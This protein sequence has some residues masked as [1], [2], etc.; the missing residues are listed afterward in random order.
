MARKRPDSWR[1]AAITAIVAIGVLAGSCPSAHAN[2]ELVGRFG[3]AGVSA[4]GGEGVAGIA[5][6]NATGDVYVPDARGHR[7]ER[8]SRDGVFL[9][10]WG[11]G[12]A[13]GAPEFQ[14]CTTTCQPEGIEGDGA[15]QFLLPQGAAVDQNTGDVYILD[16]NRIAGVIQEFTS[17]GT[18]IGAF[19][20]IGPGEAQ[21]GE[22]ARERNGIAVGAGGEVYIS[23]QS[24]AHGPRLMKFDGAGKYQTGQD[25]GVGQLAFPTAISVA[26]DGIVAIDRECVVD[27]FDMS[28]TLQWQSPESCTKESLTTDPTTDNSFI[29]THIGNQYDV[30]DSAGT[31]VGQFA[32]APEEEFTFG[33]A[34]DPS[35]TWST[36]RP[37]GVLYAI[38]FSEL[39]EHGEGLIFAQAPITP[40]SIESTSVRYVG[41]HSA[42]MTATINA[43]GSKTHYYFEVGT[44]GPCSVAKCT[45]TPA[46]EGDA[47][48][49]Q[50]GVTASVGL[51]TLAPATTY[52]YRVV[53]TNAGGQTVGAD[54]AFSTFATATTGLPDERAYELVSPR[55]KHGGQVFPPEPNGGSCITGECKPGINEAPAPMQSTPEGDVIAYE[56]SPFSPNLGPSGENEY[57]SSRTSDGWRTTDLSPFTELSGGGQGFKALSADL[58]RG[59]LFDLEPTLA[60][61]APEGYANLYSDDTERNSFTPII[62][63]RPPNRPGG[64]SATSF[65]P[66][67]AGASGDFSDVVFEANDALT[68]GAIDG[69][70]SSDNLYVWDGN[71]L[72]LANILPSGSPDGPDVA[73]GSG[74]ELTS[75]TGGQDYS[76]AISQDGSR[77]FWTDLATGQ[78]YLRE[79]TSRTVAVPDAGRFLTAGVDGRQVLLSDG[80]L[81]DLETHQLTDLTNGAG[82]FAGILGANSDLTKVFFV[83]SEA[84]GGAGVAGGNNLYL[85]RPGDLTYIAT[86]SGEDRA[87]WFLSAS[88]SASDWAASPAHRTAQVTSDGRYLAF[89]STA[90]LTKYDNHD[91]TTG[92]A[93]FEVYEYDAETNRLTCAS[94]DPT[95][96]RP[97]GPSNLSLI[98]PGAEAELPQPQNLASD[99]R[100]F[101][102][103]ED[104][105]SANDT[106]GRTQDVYEFEPTGVGTCASDNGCVYIISSGNDASDSN[107]VAASGDGSDVFFATRQ[108]LSDEDNDELLDLY[109]ARVHG[110]FAPGTVPF[111]CTGEECRGSGPS[112]PILESPA[113][114][115]LGNSGNLTQG[116]TRPNSP[117]PGARKLLTR[118]QKLK[119]ALRTCRRKRSHR[120]RASCERLARKRYGSSFKARTRSTSGLKYRQRPE[121]ARRTV[122]RAR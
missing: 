32:G 24:A 19:G 90:Q 104:T 26:A 56:G 17:D 101:F 33:L 30:L 92:N 84:L 59:I 75:S 89:M 12:V 42:E 22:V 54:A 119:I 58:S 106:N 80:R 113:S 52:H 108:Q 103:S 6:S 61:A 95:G 14:T 62:T 11:W 35:A 15:G 110:G 21:I 13:N 72:S 94:C 105:L 65:A 122:G 45:R 111:S 31:D 18:F 74:T 4:L 60:P 97:L 116:S 114:A 120:K 99:G 8:F 51:S 44:D 67:L 47:G 28:G 55:D 20:E 63:T 38:N 73:I 79:D 50:A 48:Q 98:K 121:A 77:I 87:T 82:G 96:A 68:S 41:T 23:D 88:H 112:A 27:K 102:D 7:V 107:F 36:G 37:A 9:E 86:L 93:D 115:T 81:Y 100:I 10:A 40:P 1:A 16:S 76:H 66:K 118:A 39:T 25:I 70:A 91:A 117:P 5:V 53:A 29:Y 64:R 57:I 49:S 78:V 43:H 69:G 3:E 109:D 46:V 2:Y 83:D 85:W 34:F 71:G